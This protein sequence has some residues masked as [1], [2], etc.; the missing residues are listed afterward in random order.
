MLS[1]RSMKKKRSPPKPQLPADDGLRDGR[2]CDDK[3][4]HE[5]LFGKGVPRPASPAKPR[6]A[7]EPP[8]TIIR[9]E[10]KTVQD[11]KLLSQLESL[12]AKNAAFDDRIRRLENELREERA[13]KGK[14]YDENEHLRNQLET[15]KTCEKEK[16]QLRMEKAKLR[17]DLEEALRRLEGCK[18]C[19]D[20]KRKLRAE[21]NELRLKLE[22]YAAS[23]AEIASLKREIRD[24]HRELDRNARGGAELDDLRRQLKEAL[25]QLEAC[26]TCEAEKSELRRQK[27]RRRGP[28]LERQREVGGLAPEG[29]SG[30]H[31]C[32]WGTRRG[33]SPLSRGRSTPTGDTAYVVLQDEGP[34]FGDDIEVLL[35]P[36]RERMHVTGAALC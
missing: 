23:E 12:N 13:A 15:C 17:K 5:Y 8:K 33:V 31:S 6:P 11:P 4:I 36:Q 2:W 30:W 1:P 3:N 20:D 28:Y 34:E 22:G 16:G 18:T 29:E 21:L 27:V 14:L 32:C 19:E 24:L 10:L 25:R 26:K 7:P 35:Q 9:T